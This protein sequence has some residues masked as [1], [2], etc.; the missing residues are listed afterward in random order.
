[1]YAVDA[2]AVCGYNST[3]NI[4]QEERVFHSPMA[5]P[6]PTTRRKPVDEEERAR[7]RSRINGKV[8]ENKWLVIVKI[9]LQ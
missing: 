4:V 1:L 9:C 3:P 7:K 8:T 5:M 6:P 2:A